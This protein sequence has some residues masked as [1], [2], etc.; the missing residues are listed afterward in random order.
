MPRKS[1]SQDVL[2]G[3]NKNRVVNL[4]KDTFEVT[5]FLSDSSYNHL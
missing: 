1:Y 5:I 2:A 4:G 3:V